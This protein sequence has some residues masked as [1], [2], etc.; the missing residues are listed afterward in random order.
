MKKSLSILLSLVIIFL[1]GM[2]IHA[3]MET[4]NIKVDADPFDNTIYDKYM[5]V[6]VTS[7][8]ID[9][10]EVEDSLTINLSGTTKESIKNIIVIDKGI[11]EFEML[12]Y[13]VD[14]GFYNL[15]VSYKDGNIPIQEWATQ[16]IMVK[17]G[18]FVFE[19]QPLTIADMLT[20]GITLKFY[21]VEIES[22]ITVMLDDVKTNCTKVSNRVFRIQLKNKSLIR[23]ILK[24]D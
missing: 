7:E 22:E 10:T 4:N 9:F 14:E 15:V 12:T 13:T 3:A 8:S 18:H 16:A 1:I 11:I 20:N 6:T 24:L 23:I 17:K 21:N 5:K 19:N 2:P